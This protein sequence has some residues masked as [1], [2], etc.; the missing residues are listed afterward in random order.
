MFSR[1]A[2]KGLSKKFTFVILCEA[3]GDPLWFKV[4]YLNTKSHKVLTKVHQV[5]FR[6]LI[7]DF[8]VLL[9]RLY[10]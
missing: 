5:V 6:L 7:Q 4:L 10:I 8:G 9:A 2:L 1:L 3:L